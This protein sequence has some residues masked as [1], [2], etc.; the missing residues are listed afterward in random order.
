MGGGTPNYAWRPCRLGRGR[1][2]FG[3]NSDKTKWLWVLESPVTALPSLILV[4]GDIPLLVSTGVQSK[5]FPT[6][7]AST[8]RRDSSYDHEGLCTSCTPVA[9]FL[10]SGVTASGHSGLSRLL[11][12]LLQRAICG[13]AHEELQKLELDHAVTRT[14]ADA[15]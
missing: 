14:I 2:S 5:G 11:V 15:T 3:S 6:F 10:R 8:Q 9:P 1:I 7:M 4:S 12:G 13:C